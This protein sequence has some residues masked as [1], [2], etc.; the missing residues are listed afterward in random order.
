MWLEFSLRGC[1]RRGIILSFGLLKGLGSGRVGG[2]GLSPIPEIL[3]F[4]SSG[5]RRMR[6]ACNRR[7]LSPQTDRVCV[8]VGGGGGNAPAALHPFWLRLCWVGLSPN[9]SI[10]DGL[11]RVGSLR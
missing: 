8:C 9:F 4:F 11:G 2:G 5:N 7:M 3:S 1:T 10:C 6:N